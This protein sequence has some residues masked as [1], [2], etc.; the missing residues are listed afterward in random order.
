MRDGEEYD[1]DEQLT[2]LRSSFFRLKAAAQGFVAAFTQE[3][4][5]LKTQA[6]TLLID[7][8]DIATNVGDLTINTLEGRCKWKG[9]DIMLSFTEMKIVATLAKRPDMIYGRPYL[10]DAF[11]PD[12]ED[13]RII[14]SHMK[15]IRRKFGMVDPLFN[16]ITTIYGAGYRWNR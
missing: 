4:D 12:G 8:G 5:A 7:P 1:L 16:R 10:M 15:R 2:E 11:C 3:L 13:E 14:D 9:G 6:D